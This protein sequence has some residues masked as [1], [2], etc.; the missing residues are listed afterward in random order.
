VARAPEVL[1]PDAAALVALPPVPRAEAGALAT[2]WVLRLTLVALVA[3]A[4]LCAIGPHI[5]AGE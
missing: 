5:P 3:L 2:R 1:L 4:L